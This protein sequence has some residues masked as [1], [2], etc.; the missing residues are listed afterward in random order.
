VNLE[1]RL[2]NVLPCT[3]SDVMSAAK[4]IVDPGLGGAIGPFHHITFDGGALR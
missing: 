4:P 3:S 1:P 2:G